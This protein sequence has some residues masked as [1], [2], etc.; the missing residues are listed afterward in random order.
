MY[1]LHLEPKTKPLL[2]CDTLWLL[3]TD[4]NNFFSSLHIFSITLPPQLKAMSFEHAHVILLSKATPPPHNTETRIRI[5][6]KTSSFLHCPAS[7]RP[8]KFTSK[9][10]LDVGQFLGPRSILTDPVH[11]ITR[12]NRSTKAWKTFY[13][14]QSNRTG[15]QKAE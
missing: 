10:E 1:K 7:Y 2:F 13:Q 6:L 14:I 15:L 11:R 12:P 4:C 8:R 3:L 9:S 5:V